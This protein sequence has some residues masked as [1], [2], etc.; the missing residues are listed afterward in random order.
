MQKEKELTLL[1]LKMIGG[2]RKQRVQ[3]RVE[4]RR[5]AN[6]WTFRTNISRHN[7]S[8]MPEPGEEDELEYLRK[9]KRTYAEVEEDTAYDFDGHYLPHCIAIYTRGKRQGKRRSLS[10][11]PK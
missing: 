7:S 6:G 4:L 10:R 8:R 9:L 2:Y 5:E 1:F 11:L 3:S